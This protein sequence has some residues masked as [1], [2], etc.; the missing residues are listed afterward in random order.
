MKY[1]RHRDGND[2]TNGRHFLKMRNVIVLVTLALG[3]LQT[4]S[5]GSIAGFLMWSV[6]LFITEWKVLCNGW[7]CCCYTVFIVI[8]T[9]VAVAL[10]VLSQE[11]CVGSARPHYVTS[12]CTVELQFDHMLWLD[13]IAL[14]L[15]SCE[16][17][18]YL[19]PDQDCNGLPKQLKAN[20]TNPYDNGDFIYM[21]PGSAIHFSV[22]PG[23]SGQVWV[24]SDYDSVQAFQGMPTAFSCRN[25][26]P[27]S[28]CFEAEE[29]PGPF[30]HTV[31]QAANYFIRFYPINLRGVDWYFNRSTYNFDRISNK[32]EST[33]TLTQV[34]HTL[35]F[36]HSYENSCVLLHIPERSCNYGEMLVSDATR[37]VDPQ[38]YAAIG[39]VICIVILIIFIGVH[40]YMYC[41]S[42][43][44]ALVS[45]ENI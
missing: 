4:K 2:Y 11:P 12:N 45:F 8:I 16:G 33:A 28:F 20:Y 15:S 34:P 21:L 9:L 38:I 25:P 39:L 22:N 13:H 37:R 41:R 19:I 32:Y 26:S 23:T 27:G 7:W 31:T 44:H 43:K 18:L 36:P 14:A 6:L 3:C 5:F 30:P 40:V 24:F 35:Y 10:I 1:I 17:Q 29:H 42:K